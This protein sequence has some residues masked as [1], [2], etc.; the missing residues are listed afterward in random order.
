MRQWGRSAALAAAVAL[1]AGSAPQTAPVQS[2]VQ[3]QGSQKQDAT[4]PVAQ[5]PQA[6]IQFI[7]A[8]SFGPRFAGVHPIWLGVKK[9][10]N[11]KGRSRFDY[12]R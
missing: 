10:G 3:T 5:A 6:N 1:A 12:N 11:R 2:S 7:G 4:A 9:R 8:T